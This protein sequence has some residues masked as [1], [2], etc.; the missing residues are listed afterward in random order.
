MK[1]RAGLIFR[2]LVS[3]GTVVWL[4]HQIDLRTLGRALKGFPP[5]LFA[6]AALVFILAQVLSTRRWQVLASSL[7]IRAPYGLLLRYYFVGSYFNLLMPGAIGGDVIKAYLLSKG[8]EGKLRISY[9]IVGDRGFG[10]GAIL[11]L[12]LGGFLLKPDIVPAAGRWPL[13]LVL[14]G[15]NL[16]FLAAPLLSSIIR[17]LFP[18][19][20]EDIFAFWRN[21]LVFLEAYLLSVLVQLLVITFHWM[22]GK[23]LGLPY[24][25]GFYLV[26]VPLISVASSL[27]LSIS[28]IGIREGGFAFFLKHLGENPALGVALGILAF[29]VSLVVGAIGGIVYLFGQHERGKEALKIHKESCR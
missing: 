3:L 5:H 23:G 26:V 22:L 9:S 1:L 25:F 21:R 19:F 24:G 20:P 7:R 17:R 8:Q 10:L 13:F 18:S 16:I 4:I 6:L 11:G 27:P 29:G 28:G 2:T 15:G 14:A 12:S